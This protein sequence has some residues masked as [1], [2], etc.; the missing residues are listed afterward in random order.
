M[1]T[2]E[3]IDVENLKENFNLQN[4]VEMF[5]MYPRKPWLYMMLYLG[6]ERAFRLVE[7]KD[8][9]KDIVVANVFV[10]DNSV[11]DK[12]EYV[13]VISSDYATLWAEYEMNYFCDYEHDCEDD[14]FDK[15]LSYTAVALML[16]PD[17]WYAENCLS[18]FDM[19]VEREC[20]KY[21]KSL[22]EYTQPK[23]LTNLVGRLLDA[24][25]GSLYNPYAGI[26]SYSQIVGLNVKYHGQEVSGAYFIGKLRC[27]IS[28][29]ENFEIE[30]G[31]ESWDRWLGDS[32]QFD[33]IVSTPPFSL[34]LDET[35]S[36]WRDASI[37]F[38]ERSSRD[39][40]KK[41]V[42]VYPASIC[43]HA[44]PKSLIKDLIT[45]DIL[46]TVVLLPKNI[47]PQT[48][49][50]TAIIVVNKEKTNR[51]F[52]RLIDASECY[53][54]KG[55]KNV[56]DFETVSTL[57]DCDS[58]NRVKVISN[59]EISN[60][61]YDIT[62][63]VYAQ[64]QEV[65]F[66]EGYEIVDFRDILEQCPTQKQY[67]AENGYIAKIPQLS[68]DS[69]DCE[70]KIEDFE[71]FI[72]V[73]N[74]V[75][76][77]EPVILISR[78]REAKPTYCIASSEKP[79][80]I[81]ANVIPF[82]IKKDCEW[83]EPHYLCLELS[84][85]IKN[86]FFGANIPSLSINRLVNVRLAFPSRLFDE[87]KRLFEVASYQSKLA[88]AQELGLQEVIDKLKAE[89]MNEVRA[90]RHDMSP[91]I[92]VLDMIECKLRQY[93]GQIDMR[94]DMSE[95]MIRALDYYRAALDE[96]KK[97]VDVL[98]QEN[99]FGNSEV[100]DL[101]VY[102]QGRLNNTS[103]YTIEYTCDSY[104]VEE[105]LIEDPWLV[106]VDSRYFARVVNN[107]IVNAEKHGFVD[108][109]RKDYKLDIRLG[110]NDDR[111]MYQIDFANN[112]KSLPA[113]FDKRLYGI[114]GEK[115]GRTAGS[116][117]GGHIVKSFVENYNGDYDLFMDNNEVVI[118]IL[119]P[120]F[121]KGE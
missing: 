120:I 19:I 90:R 35:V 86:V 30:C 77:E 79:L 109:E 95:K 76:V 32:T 11:T 6:K 15:I 7:K 45:R 100:I 29:K 63:K 51:G 39:A 96:L 33:Y 117:I 26:C 55:R 40:R 94:E 31:D 106:N 24:D 37:D 81:H 52:V 3:K 70:R 98:S 64:S 16:L 68:T 83:V 119:L 114:R 101:N 47:F 36:K 66:P 92:G 8:I 28:G 2:K 22:S 49:I 75:K 80:F 4:A 38:L 91:H 103:G 105:E 44:F 34:E 82:R 5:L 107:I 12:S 56:L 57:L 41:S 88:K 71:Y 65:A 20:E 121:R 72:G 93:V 13:I 58:D 14:F 102:F 61:E 17:E 89:Y 78:I 23:E 99:E 84:N 111:T 18:T 21:A 74:V 10:T 48:A 73:D 27:L 54:Q 97:I 108:S 113:G 46:D 69:F 104:V 60:N 59:N 53:F 85:R 116:G 50:Q 87:Q 25:Y 110:L 62:P 1:M 42:G 115:A 112:G 118:R 43:Y 9:G 67:Y